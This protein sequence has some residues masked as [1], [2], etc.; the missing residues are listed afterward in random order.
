[1]VT[2]IEFTGRGCGACKHMEPV[3]KQLQAEGKQISVLDSDEN[4][5]AAKLYNIS[6]LP[7]LVLLKS[8]VEKTR[9][10][11]VTPIKTLREAFKDPD[12][13]NLW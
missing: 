4:R 2:G 6:A 5:E 11:G 7:T 1:M 3:I 10:V 12:D 13:Q 9:F 8:D